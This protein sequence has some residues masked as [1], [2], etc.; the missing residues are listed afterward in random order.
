LNSVLKTVVNGLRILDT[1]LL[2]T[3]AKSKALQ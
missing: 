2:K 1:N 3:E